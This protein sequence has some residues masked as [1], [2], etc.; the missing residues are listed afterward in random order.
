MGKKKRS[1][2]QNKKQEEDEDT[3][4]LVIYDA[5]GHSSKDIALHKEDQSSRHVIEDVCQWLSC[6]G[7]E[8]WA[9]FSKTTVRAPSEQ[10]LRICVF[11]ERE[12]GKLHHCS[13]AQER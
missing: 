7:L 8:V 1:Q 10:L 13:S 9:M 4:F 11:T 5:Y 2:P 6:A 3:V 12:E